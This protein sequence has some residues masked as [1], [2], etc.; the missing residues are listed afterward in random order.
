MA[1]YLMETL[2]SRGSES[3]DIPPPLEYIF[4]DNT[5]K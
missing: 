2:V 1:L 5:V 4:E 3:L